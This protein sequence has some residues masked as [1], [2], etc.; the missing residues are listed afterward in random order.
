MKLGQ[1]DKPMHRVLKICL[2]MKAGRYLVSVT[3]TLVRSRSAENQN[4]QL[5][6]RK[7]NRKYLERKFKDF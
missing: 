5:K 1:N 4:K 3:A 2:E 7:I 6:Q